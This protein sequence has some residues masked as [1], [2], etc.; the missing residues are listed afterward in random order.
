MEVEFGRTFSW[1]VQMAMGNVVCHSEGGEALHRNHQRATV[2]S[3]LQLEQVSTPSFQLRRGV[4]PSSQ[5]PRG[6]VAHTPGRIHSEHSTSLTNPLSMVGA[7]NKLPV[8][9]SGMIFFGD[10]ATTGNVSAI[11]V[12]GLAGIVYAVAK[13]NQAK[14]DAANRQRLPGGS[15]A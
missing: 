4:A 2:P 11:G 9:A 13:T 7:L 6:A 15:K 12:G 1:R 10:K 14:V 3:E 5:Q 8:A